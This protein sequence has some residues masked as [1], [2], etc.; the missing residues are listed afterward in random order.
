MAIWFAPFTLPDLNG[1]LAA[2]LAAHLGIEFTG[3]GD[4]WLAA[5]MPVDR[6]TRQPM[7]LLHGG[8]SLALA[9]T[10]GGGAANLCV[11]RA[12]YRCR[13]QEINGNHVRGVSTGRVTATARPLH[14]GARSHVWQV[15]I[16]D[17]AARLVCVSRLTLAV[18]AAS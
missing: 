16:R 3:C 11:D 12:H 8:A 6:R 13:V 7:G 4:D 17:S 18:V 10:V 15:E 2:G 9:A 1:T 5:A 14:V